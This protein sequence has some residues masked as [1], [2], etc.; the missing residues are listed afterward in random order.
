VSL[1]NDGSG[2]LSADFYENKIQRVDTPWGWT[3][4]LRYPEDIDRINKSNIIVPRP[5]YL[6]LHGDVVPEEPDARLLFE[7]KDVRFYRLRTVRLCVADPILRSAAG[8]GRPRGTRGE[9]GDRRR[10]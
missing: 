4:A 7:E 6:V 5:K 2:G 9:R 10:M 8:K 3:P 1:G